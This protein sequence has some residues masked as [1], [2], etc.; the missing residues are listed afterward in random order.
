MTGRDL[1]AMLLETDDFDPKDYAMPGGTE[2]VDDV[3]EDENIRIVQP[4]D[5]N[6]YNDLMRA[7]RKSRR[8]VL[9]ANQ[10]RE[11][12]SLGK[13]YIIIPKSE[14]LNPTGEPKHGPVALRMG[15]DIEAWNGW[16]HTFDKISQLQNDLG[17]AGFA[18]AIAGLT[19]YFTG[20]AKHKEGA[21]EAVRNLLIMGRYDDAVKHGRY[22]LPHIK[23][24]AVGH[25]LGAALAMQAKGKRPGNRITRFM[26]NQEGVKFTDTGFYLL[27]P[28]WE[29]V[30]NVAI[31]T[32]HSRFD[33]MSTAKGALEGEMDWL[34]D[35]PYHGDL[36]DLV[37]EVDGKA[38]KMLRR[39]L[40][41]RT[42]TDEDDGHDVLITE[43][44]ANGLPESEIARI[45]ENDENDE[46]SDIVDRLKWAAADTEKSGIEAAYYS[47]YKGLIK[48]ALGEEKEIDGQHAFFFPYATLDEWVRQ[49]QKDLGEDFYME[50]IDLHSLAK[51]H[52]EKQSPPEDVSHDWDT[53]YFNE[54][55]ESIT[56]TRSRTA[57][58]SR[59]PA[60]GPGPTAAR[61]AAG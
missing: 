25:S 46:F 14:E 60:A 12:Q 51:E 4:R 21:R 24:V 59:W 7:E 27:F 17:E 53:D 31:N 30:I 6:T 34:Q 54:Q 23:D 49:E 22:H 58:C 15:R 9:D 38:L 3:Y 2:S 40:I 45:L 36:G 35:T 19:K 42:Y 28:D 57:T 32:E 13:L 18:S 5:V 61:N 16:G 56:C 33:V 44:I 52:I 29:D 37:N 43:E 26:R 41:G 1:A 20:R 8:G 11:H 10:F 55:L 48:E 50:N 47:A 39:K